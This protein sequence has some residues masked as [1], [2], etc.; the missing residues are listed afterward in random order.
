MRYS[1]LACQPIF[2]MR[3]GSSFFRICLSL[4]DSDLGIE[5]QFLHKYQPEYAPEQLHGFDVLISLKPR[6]TEASLIGVERL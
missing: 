5:H 4:L 6:V 3:I 1:G 2:S